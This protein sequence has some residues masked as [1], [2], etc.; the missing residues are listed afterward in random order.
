MQTNQCTN[1][2]L[3]PVCQNQTNESYPTEQIVTVNE[4]KRNT[5]LLHCGLWQWLTRSPAVAENE[6][7]VRRCLE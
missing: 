2:Q 6:P 4:C 7:I 1:K 5:K 3:V